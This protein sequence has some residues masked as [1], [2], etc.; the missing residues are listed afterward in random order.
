MFKNRN[1]FIIFTLLAAVACGDD[2]D[3]NNGGSGVDQNAQISTLTTSEAQSAC[4]E[5]ASR[6]NT[7][8]GNLDLNQ[9]VCTSAALVTT[10]LTNGTE[11]DCNNAVT[12]CLENPPP[13][14][15]LEQVACGPIAAADLMG[16]N[17]TVAQFNACID[18]AIGLLDSVV[19]LFTCS[20]L[21][22]SAEELA[23]A[24][25]LEEFD[26]DSLAACEAF[27]DACPGLDLDD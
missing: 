9:L 1:A 10:Q 24:A 18:E 16:C 27:N 20:N 14:E 2:D 15:E 11:Q 12:M 22:I 23:E 3:S 8:V 17:A 6:L 13:S 19:D 26:L 5:G 7:A 21:N 25:A 4:N